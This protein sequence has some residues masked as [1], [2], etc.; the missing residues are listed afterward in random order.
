M[1]KKTEKKGSGERKSKRAHAEEEGKRKSDTGTVGGSTR[2]ARSVL[3]CWVQYGPQPLI[4]GSET[5]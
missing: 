2:E 1:T 3:V 4:P 5:K